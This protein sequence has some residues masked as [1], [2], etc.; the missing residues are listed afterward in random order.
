MKPVNFDYERPSDLLSALGSLSSN[1]GSSKLI[2]GGQSLGP[3]M[4]LRLARPEKLIDVSHLDVLRAVSETNEA[5][6]V[7]AAI[8]HAELED[9]SAPNPIPDPIPGMLSSVAGGIAYRVIRNRGTIGGSIAHADPAADWISML[10]A[11]DA[12]IHIASG[13]GETVTA[14]RDFMLGAYT[15]TLK[16]DQ[17]ITRIEIPKYSGAARWGYYRICRKVGELSDAIGAVVVDPQRDYCRVVL[18]AIGGAPALLKTVACDL[19]RTA[20]L[21]E[22]SIINAEI[23]QLLPGADAASKQ[24]FAIAVQRTLTQVVSP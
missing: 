9:G 17:I 7:G 18:G 8:T 11:A 21:P 19:A 16:A 24:L 12:K 20:V 3:M 5:V 10:T 22:L 1:E 23:E 4:N 6:F 2:S 14:L 15:T 13:E